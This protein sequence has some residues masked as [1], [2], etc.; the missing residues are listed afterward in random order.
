VL[1]IATQLDTMM[2]KKDTSIDK[3]NVAVS[4]ISLKLDKIIEKKDEEKVSETISISENIR[5][6]TATIYPDDIDISLAIVAKYIDLK[7]VLPY[8]SVKAAQERV[9]ME[10]EQLKSAEDVARKE[11]LDLNDSLKE[12]KRFVGLVSPTIDPNSLIS[13]RL[14]NPLHEYKLD[15]IN[16]IFSGYRVEPPKM[17]PPVQVT[18]HPYQLEEAAL[19]LTDYFSEEELR[20]KWPKV[21]EQS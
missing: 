2:T 4:D 11:Q 7:H 14:V 9:A 15:E 3:V 1:D 8:Y 20:E 12:H 16:R 5:N 10:K 18:I 13:A 19:T 17:L 6:I 21:N